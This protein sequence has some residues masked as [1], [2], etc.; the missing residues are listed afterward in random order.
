MPATLL[1]S[2]GTRVSDIGSFE[3]PIPVNLR[4]DLNP[5]APIPYIVVLRDKRILTN[6]HRII[7]CT[8]YH[9][10]LPFLRSYHSDTTAASKASDT[11]LVTDGTQYHN[12]H[13]DI[14]YIPDPTLAFVGVP[15]FT[16]TFTLFEFQAIALAAVWSGK[17]DLPSEEEMRKEYKEKLEKKGSGK[18]FHSLK[19][20]EVAYASSLVEWLN[21]DGAKVG[22]ELV[23]GHDAAWHVA[24]A[25]RIALFR[26]KGIIAAEVGS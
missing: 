13:K 9:I 19:G 1:P 6:I 14:F 18:G 23:E 20:E 25:D 5:M 21:R 12:L 10:S 3:T 11:I 2:N 17:A 24:N 7:I 4:S 8:G 16:A 15:Y 26:Q 22:A